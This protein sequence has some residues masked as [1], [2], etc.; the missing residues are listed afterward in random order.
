M[1]ILGANGAGKSTLIEAIAWAFYGSGNRNKDILRDGKDGIKNY[2]ASSKEECSVKIVFEFAGT[3]YELVRSL[4][5]KNN[6]PNATLKADGVQLASTDSAVTEHIIKL[7]GMESREFYIT[8]FSKQ[9]DLTA[10]SEM[11]AAERKEHI[12][13][14]LDIDILKN[15]VDRV[16]KDIKVEKQVKETLEANLLTAEGEPKKDYLQREKD[17]LSAEK[18]EVGSRIM[19]LQKQEEQLLSERKGI[20]AELERLE[21]INKKYLEAKNAVVSKQRELAIERDHLATTE[22]EIASLKQKL[23]QL[24]EL[25]MKFNQYETMLQE[26]EVLEEQRHA[27]GKR[28]DTA[29]RVA[30]IAQ[31]IAEA[32]QEV[33]QNLEK[34]EQFSGVSAEI[35]ANEQTII[36]L[37][38]KIAQMRTKISELEV[39]SRENRKGEKTLTEK[40]QTMQER[41]PDSICPECERTLGEHHSLLLKKLQKELGEKTAEITAIVQE[42][43][44]LLSIANEEKAHLEALKRRKKSLEAER[45]QGVELSASVRQLRLQL[46]KL[47]QEKTDAEKEL[48]AIGT[49][50][51]DEQQ[52]QKVTTELKILK[53]ASESYNQLRGESKNLP[54]LEKRKAENERQILQKTTELDNLQKNLQSIDYQEEAFQKVKLDMSE[55]DEKVKNIQK[56]KNQQR[57]QF[58]VVDERL[59]NNAKEL[60]G[61][62]ETVARQKELLVKISELETL[63]SVFKDLKD[64]LMERIIP[65]LSEI[66]SAIFCEMTD[67]RYLGLELDDGYNIII[68]D[69]A[70]KYPINRFSG[71]EMDLAN[72]CLRLAISRLLSERSGKDI[73]FLVLDEIFGSQDQSRKRNIMSALSKLENQFNQ[74]LL[75]THIDDVKDLMQNVI[76]VR[77]VNENE[78]VAELIS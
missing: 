58:A 13:K 75:I 19:L 37:E 55:M 67:S 45:Q 71:G 26:K 14:L 34:L 24:P 62:A 36:T 41:G 61:L 52:Y 3:N 38:E 5:G 23:Q 9:K 46:T 63:N 1:G 57:I 49:V 42:K 16:N 35:E 21:L 51:F 78:S 25:E 8:I 69:G 22:N 73:N 20:A 54:S 12:V 39:S 60:I 31:K 48:S 68:Y 43:E 17:A 28:N 76:A 2:N 47:N 50:V 66:A 65:A 32:D 72:L 33:Q 27:F 53:I 15:V 70:E 4:K 7:M 10:L 18:T 59:N 77:D 44:E 64:N 29:A 11:G 30:K 56:E 40:I 6:T 74:I